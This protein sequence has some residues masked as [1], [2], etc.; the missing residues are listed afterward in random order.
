[1]EIMTENM[2]R[3]CEQLIRSRDQIKN[4]FPWDGGLIHLACAGIYVMK[5]KEVDEGVLEQSKRLLKE[6]MG[7]FSNFRGTARSPIAAMMAVSCNPERTLDN[8]IAVYELL[9]KEFW[10][11]PY[12]PLAAM[13]I[14]Q[15]VESSN[16]DKVAGRTRRIY[17]LMKAEHPFL[18]SGE[19]SSFCALSAL[20][21]RS[22]DDLI[23]DMEACFK[24]LKP[25]F[26][27]GNAVQSLAHVLSLCEGTP[28]EKCRRTLEL[29][30][31]LK[32]AGRKYGTEYE[33]PTLGIFAMTD[34]DSGQIVQEMLEIDEWLSAQKG[35]GM[36]GSINKKQRLMYAG[37]LAQKEHIRA[38]VVQTAAVN[39]TVAL[40]VAQEAAMCAAVAASTAA[41][42]AAS[43]ASN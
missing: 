35:F 23:S 40:V 26:F 1:M 15:L 17:E 9:K 12:L 29:F 16:Y 25:E 37:M 2:R 20:S 7:I 27:S 8:G 10:S 21:D 18:T 43:S 28:E 36:L 6:K 31:N 41:A 4:V 22:D 38:D 30:N 14:A 34:V 3:N 11:S 19:D 24:L 32:A 42:A 33:L 39:S 5:G 13:V